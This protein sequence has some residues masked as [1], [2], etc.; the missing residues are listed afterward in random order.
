VKEKIRENSRNSWLNFVQ[1]ANQS[2]LNRISKHSLTQN[3]IFQEQVNLQREA[4]TAQAG[5]AGFGPT[6][7]AIANQLV[8]L[9]STVVA[10]AT[11]QYLPSATPSPFC[12]GSGSIPPIPSAPPSGCILIVEW[13]VKPNPTPCGLLITRDIPS[14][15]PSAAVG[16]WYVVYPSRPDSHIKEFQARDIPCEIK[17][18]R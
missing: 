10:L 9:E 17:D 18:L 15:V 14:S 6:T 7:T 3:A 1:K 16:T 4:V 8:D 11:L 12:Y 2:R 5:G 13:W